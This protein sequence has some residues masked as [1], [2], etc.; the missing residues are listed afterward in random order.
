[1][2]NCD[3][4]CCCQGFS[5]EISLPQERYAGYIKDYEGATLMGCE[6][7]SRIMYT[8]FSQIIKL[9]KEVSQWDGCAWGV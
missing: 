9:Q 1:M 2:L 7:N 5:K 8:E 3:V 4:T 6:L